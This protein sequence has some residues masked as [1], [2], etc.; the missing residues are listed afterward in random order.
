VDLYDP[1]PFYPRPDN[2]IWPLI[3]WPAD[4]RPTNWYLSDPFTYWPGDTIWPLISWSA[5]Q[6]STNWYLSDQ[7]SYWPHDTIWPLISWSADQRS[8][9]WYLSDLFTYWPDDTIWPLISWPDDQRSTN[10]HRYLSGDRCCGVVTTRSKY[11]VNTA[12]GIE[13]KRLIDCYTA[14]A[15]WI[16]IPGQQDITKWNQYLT[17]TCLISRQIHVVHWMWL[18]M[19]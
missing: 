12:S 11:N 10:W 9:N 13:R 19:H 3:S 2:T 18:F 7:F 5:D 4:Q 6:R 1:W 14:V 17:V 15:P 16:C 8:T